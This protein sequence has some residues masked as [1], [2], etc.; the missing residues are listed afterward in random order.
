MAGGYTG[1]LAALIAL[2]HKRRTGQG[3]FVDL[4][5]FEAVVSVVG[6]ALLDI[7]VNDREQAPPQYN[8]QEGAGGSARRLSMRAAGR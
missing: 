8:S 2:Y 5:Q 1:A 3:Q 7:A 4:S 6:P